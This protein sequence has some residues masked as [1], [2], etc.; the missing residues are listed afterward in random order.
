MSH[1][2]HPISGH[3][4]LLLDASLV[5][6]SHFIRPRH[7]IQAL[8]APGWQAH[9]LPPVDLAAAERLMLRSHFLPEGSVLVCTQCGARIA[10]GRSSA[11]R[12]MRADGYRRCPKRGR[13]NQIAWRSGETAAR[14]TP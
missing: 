13:G 5:D 3:P 4:D 11:V 2:L 8:F 6:G 9:L 7:R 1:Q 10:G 14:E 12:H